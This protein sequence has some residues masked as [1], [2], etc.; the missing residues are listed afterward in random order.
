M[1]K[2]ILI[3][4]FGLVCLIIVYII[5]GKKDKLTETEAIT[6]IPISKVSDKYE[7]EGTFYL[8][9]VLDNHIVEA[10]HLA[11]NEV[12]FRTSEKVYHEAISGQD[13]IG[14]T[15]KIIPPKDHPKAD[16]GYILKAKLTTEYCEIISLK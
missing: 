7:K 5:L 8:T 9:V 11:Y 3:L 4:I 14:V 12:T 1:V 16:I 6:A 15:L 10:Y 2:R 13:Y